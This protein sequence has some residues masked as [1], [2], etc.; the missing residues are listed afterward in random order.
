MSR[1]ITRRSVVS[2]ERRAGGD[3]YHVAGGQLRNELLEL[4]SNGVGAGHLLAEDRPTPGGLDMANLIVEV[5]G[6]GRNAGIAINHGPLLPQM[7]ALE[8]AIFLAAF[9]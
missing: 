7:F 2:R 5:L 8:S 4:R 9:P 3:D 6:G 1:A